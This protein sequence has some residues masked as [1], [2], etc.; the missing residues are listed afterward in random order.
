MGK[1]KSQGTVWEGNWTPKALMGDFCDGKRIMRAITK[2]PH[3]FRLTGSRRRPIDPQIITP[4]A[5]RGVASARVN[6]RG[7][8]KGTRNNAT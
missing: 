7:K 5:A 3:E 1:D 4:V 8:P 6:P 2:L